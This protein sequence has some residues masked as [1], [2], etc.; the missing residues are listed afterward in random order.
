M[1]LAVCGGVWPFGAVWCL[2]RGGAAVAA[3]SHPVPFPRAARGAAWIV[4]L[5]PPPPPPPPADGMDEGEAGDALFTQM[6]KRAK[7]S[8]KEPVR[9]PKLYEMRDFVKE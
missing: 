7:A 2:S 6:L 9:D 5:A 3:T 8:R 1:E 4:D